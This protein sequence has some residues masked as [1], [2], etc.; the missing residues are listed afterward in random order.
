MNETLK[1]QIN[2]VT[3]VPSRPVNK[4]Y[5]YKVPL[6]LQVTLGDIVVVPFGQSRAMGIVAETEVAQ[7]IDSD[8]YK[9]IIAVAQTP[10]IK[11]HMIDF[12]KWVSDYTMSSFGQVMKMVIPIQDI[13]TEE[14]AVTVYSLADPK[15]ASQ[16]NVT[17]KRKQVLEYLSQNHNA[18]AAQI[19][20][21]TNVSA[22]VVAAMAKAGLLKKSMR[23]NDLGIA[24]IPIDLIKQ[25]PLTVDQKDAATKLKSNLSAGQFSV[26]VLDGVTGSG[27][28]EV[29]LS[30]VRDVIRQEKQCLILVPEIALTT[31][32]IERFT[33]RFGVQPALW[34]STMTTAQRRKTYKGI[35]T[36]EVKVLVGARSALFLP[37]PNLAMIVVDEEHDSGYKQEDGVF[38]HARD[39][40]VKRAHIENIPIV[41]VSATPSLETHIN[42]LEGRYQ[43]VSLPDRYGG[44]HMPE[45]HVV[46]MRLEKIPRTQFI[47]PTLLKAL[48]DALK[49][50]E[51]VMLYLNRRGYAPLT[52]CRTCGHRLNCP[53]CTTWL[54]EHKNGKKL[55]C[56]HCGYQDW[57]PSECPKCDDQ[58]SF[59]ACGPGVERI[60]DEIMG[61]F[62]DK[63]IAI[64]SSDTQ[65]NPANLQEMLSKIEK[66]DMDI[67]IGTQ[68]IAKGHHFPDLTIVGVVDADLGL[69]GGDLR[70]SERTY[71][72][73]HQVAGRAG[74]AHKKGHVFLQSFMPKQ[75]VIQ[76]LAQ[77]ERDAFLMAEARDRQEM[78]LPPYGRLVALI[79]SSDHDDKA[80]QQAQNLASHVVLAEGVQVL[81]PTPAILYKLRNRYRYRLLM[82]APKNL[83]VQKLIQKWIAQTPKIKGVRIQIDIDPYSFM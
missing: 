25:T 2:L 34:H 30:P 78:Q 40:A 79:I 64:L 81:G 4:G 54:V 70:A 14:P 43:R 72:L 27:K 17:P 60:H 50:D 76:A 11:K 21:H 26:T 48:E 65:K 41:L 66:G 52:L 5:T 36:G 46:D 56:H 47:S 37:F 82:R 49:R 24:S 68:I 15:F 33:K 58:E 20:A 44:A 31:Q 80:R 18:S 13:M 22:G 62:P 75:H 67:I 74:R 7:T 45:I 3:V 71:Q 16:K 69:S 9:N 55:L 19:K 38:Y 32:F 61:Y 77:N 1:N 57:I 73:L 8:Q 42:A 6:N 63:K 10:P 53:R 83:P 35:L 23:V 29:Y 39:M 12:A 51:Q 59:V 28:T